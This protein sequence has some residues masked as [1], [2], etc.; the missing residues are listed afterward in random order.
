MRQVL[1]GYEQTPHI[2]LIGGAGN[3]SG[4]P[5]HL[6]HLTE[7]IDPRG[8]VTILSDQNE[9]GFDAAIQ[10]GAQ[11]ITIKGLAARRN[12]PRILT[13]WIMLIRFLNGRDFDLIWFHARLPSLLGRLALAL[14]IWRTA[15]PVAVTFHG[16]PFGRGRRPLE[17]SFSLCIEKWLL[18]LAPPHHLVMLNDEMAERFVAAVSAGRTTRHAIHVLQNCSDIGPLKHEKKPGQKHLVMTGRSGWQKDYASAVKLFAALPP[19]FLLSL[20]G[21]G[22]QHGAFQHKIGRRVATQVLER[23]RFVGPVSDVRPYLEKADAYLL[24][25]RYEGVPIGAIEAFE[26]GLPVL[27]SPFEG[28]QDLVDKHPCAMIL[29][30]DNVASTAAKIVALLDRYERNQASYCAETRGVWRK[31]WSFDRFREDCC[32]LITKLQHPVLN[33]RHCDQ[34]DLAPPRGADRRGPI[35]AV[36]QVGDR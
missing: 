26:A 24:T 6:T 5:R 15:T 21:S 31:H 28:A 36:E 27:L 32:A 20:C 16:L 2:L 25:S 18:S 29:D 4:V 12:I 35:Q 9:G 3:H 22:T 30:I 23:I 19:H 10:K 8:K 17:S 33:Q 1:D 11:H 13:A 7:A 14:R 34:T